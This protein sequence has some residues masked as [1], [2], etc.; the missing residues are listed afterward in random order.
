MKLNLKKIEIN[1]KKAFFENHFDKI[2]T[3]I[4]IFII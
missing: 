1:K 2:H 4:S 3:R